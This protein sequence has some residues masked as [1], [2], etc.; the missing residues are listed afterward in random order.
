MYSANLNFAK[1]SRYLAERYVMSF[2]FKMESLEIGLTLSSLASSH[3][4]KNASS[5]EQFVYEII[6]E[7]DLVKHIGNGNE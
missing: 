6:T 4:N 3:G 1:G 7:D 2:K 5:Y